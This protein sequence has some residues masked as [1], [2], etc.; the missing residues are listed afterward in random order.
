MSNLS[1]EN[2][3]IYHS[4]IYLNFI[5]NNDLKIFYCNICHGINLFKKN[6]I[7]CKTISFF[8]NKQNTELINSFLLYEQMIFS[9]KNNK[10]KKLQNDNDYELM[11]KNSFELFKGLEAKYKTTEDTFFLAVLYLDIINSQIKCSLNDWELL[12]VACFFIAGI[13][14][15]G[16]N[17]FD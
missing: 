15:Y 16:K 8:N 5:I 7:S 11:R 1:R 14:F 12:S 17:I 2:N 4:S 9:E 13:F 3:C 10:P 6:E